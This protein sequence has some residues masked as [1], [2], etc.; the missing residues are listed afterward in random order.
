MPALMF[1]DL[2][3]AAPVLMCRPSQI[4]RLGADHRLVHWSVVFVI[5]PLWLVLRII[6]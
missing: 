2:K 4:V 1:R 3:E 6:D 5:L